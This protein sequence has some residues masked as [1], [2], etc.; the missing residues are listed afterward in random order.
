MKRSVPNFAAR[1]TV[2]QEYTSRYY[3]RHKKPGDRW[4]IR[5]SVEMGVYR[6]H[7]ALA[8]EDLIHHL[9]SD[10]LATVV[11]R[12]LKFMPP[13]VRNFNA[14]ILELRSSAGSDLSRARVNQLRVG[15]TEA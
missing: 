15:S 12:C 10:F 6:T 13:L 4:W 5:L 9:S 1:L 8:T 2:H 3:G 14:L 7:H 11:S